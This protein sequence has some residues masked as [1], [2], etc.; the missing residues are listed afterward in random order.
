MALFSKES[1]HTQ[2][3]QVKES[4][5]PGPQASQSRA[6]ERTAPASQAAS[7]RQAYLDR[8]SKMEGKLNFKRSVRVDG[9]IDGEISAKDLII[10][11]SALV[12]AQIKAAS[13]IVAGTING[14]I[15]ASQSIEIRASARISGKLTSPILVMHEGAAF[16]GHCAMQ[17]EKAHAVRKSTPLAKEEL[18]AEQTKGGGQDS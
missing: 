12:T 7:V 6:K 18:A 1:E 9:Q 13:V 16:E 4:Q 11:E 8:D 14:D 15:I 10:G 3:E 5:S 17:S 2:P